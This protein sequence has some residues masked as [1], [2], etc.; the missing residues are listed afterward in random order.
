MDLYGQA[1]ETSDP[2][3]DSS[4]GFIDARSRAVD[5]NKGCNAPKK[6]TS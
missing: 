6:E 5:E 2:V 1:V 3:P 4:F